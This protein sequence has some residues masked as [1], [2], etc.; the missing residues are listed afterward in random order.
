MLTAR[1]TVGDRV[2]GLD[3]GADDYLVKP[4]AYD[5]LAA[6][7]RALARRAEGAARRAEPRLVAGPIAL[8]EATRSVT[9]HDRPVDLSPRE[10]SLLESLLRHPGQA[11]SRDQ[12]LDQAWPF[13]VAVTPNA[14]DAYVHYLRTKLGT[15]GRPDRDRARRR[16]PSERCLTERASPRSGDPADE[17]ALAADGRLIR[18]VRWRLVLWSG[19]TTLVVLAVLGVA[20]YVSAARTLETNGITQLDEPDRADRRPAREPAPPAGG[21]G[22]R[23]HLRRQLVRDVRRRRRR[24]R[25]QR[26][27]RAGRPAAR[28]AGRGCPRRRGR[29]RPRRPPIDVQTVDA[30]GRLTLVP[31]R[32]VTE[33][34]VSP[35]RRTVYIQVDPGPDR[36]AADARRDPDRAPVGGLLVVLVA[37]GFGTFYASRALVPIRESL[38][39]QRA[40]LRRQREFA[41]DASHELRTPLTVIRSSVEHLRRNR[42]GDGRGDVAEALDD[43]DAEV[44]N[45]TALVE[46]LL[47]LARSDSGAIALTRLPVDLGDVAADGAGALVKA[48]ARPRRPPRRSTRSRRSSTATRPGSASSIVIL[49]DNAIRHS[50]RGGNVRVRVRGDRRE[51]TLEVD[52]DGPGIRP[53]DM[54]HV[55]ER[56]WRAPGAAAGGTGL[57]LAIAKSIVDLHDGRIVVTNRP[58][59][60]ARFIVRLPVAGGPPV[61]QTQAGSILATD[62]RLL[63][64]VLRTTSDAPARIRSRSASRTTRRPDG[65]HHRLAYWSTE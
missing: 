32:V 34:A 44:G 8:D 16:V 47:L 48:A 6:R 28:P 43:I 33:R 25:Q 23:L 63:T 54:P 1:D 55:F 9:I 61:A 30:D 22:L 15:R 37:F 18:G 17:R 38:V 40:A 3:S 50:P 14:V 53:E 46:D 51:A 49:V 58:E 52:D 7:L 36:R 56:F 11:L 45:L 65:R 60:G 12:L 42:P 62:Q 5:E 27:P 24:E 19:L 10:F 59:G 13:G 21:P 29:A 39:Q 31:I 41:A 2:V 26:R 35:D 57:G 4:F 64:R 20:L